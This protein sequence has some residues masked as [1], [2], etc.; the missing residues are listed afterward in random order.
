MRS[1]RRSSSSAG[2][3]H[4]T[5]ILLIVTGGI[6]AYK[7][8]LLVRL[9]RRGGAAVRVVMTEAA[10]A[11][12][13]PLTFGV[14]SGHPVHRTLFG[15]DGGSGVAHI[16][17]AR[18]ADSIVVA[19]A[20]AD[21]LARA[22]AGMGDDLACTVLL[23]ARCPVYFAPSMNEAMWRH[24]TVGRN[25]ETLRRDGH[26]FVETGEGELACGETGAGR[27][28]EPEAIVSALV[29]DHGPGSLDGVRV[30]VTAGRTEE[31]IDPVRYLSNRSSG[32]MGFALASRAA[33]MGA[34]VT[35]IHGAVDIPVPS[36][37]R[38][39]RVGTAA[40]MKRAVTRAFSRCDLLVMAAAVSDYTPARTAREKIKR[41]A[42]ALSIELRPTTDI[43]AAVCAAKDAG[44]VVVG[45]ALETEHAERNARMKAKRKGCDYLVL[46]RVG[47]RT[48]FT[49][50]TN[51]VILFKGT[52]KVLETPLVP[53][54]EAAGALL[55]RIAADRRLRHGR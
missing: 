29:R 17:L 1:R 55:E 18:W 25:I 44:Q 3:L 23:A 42:D 5:K 28:A 50:E 51:R 10:T 48:G 7:S 47:T 46:N 31:R 36:V 54:S 15:S 35:L 19:P 52:R 38:V 4:D 20:T 43:L 53:K 39:V 21:F 49:A 37:E 16:D 33:L 41:G 27:M 40:E 13:S 14:L 8:A 30:L 26:R 12:V 22:A 6:A 34:R 9:L 45:F 11:F 32:R 24:P 2:G